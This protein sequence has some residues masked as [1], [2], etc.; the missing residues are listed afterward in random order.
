MKQTGSKQNAV[1]CWVREIKAVLCGEP[2]AK[3]M[4]LW[5]CSSVSCL[6]RPKG[7]TGGEG[8]EGSSLYFYAILSFFLFLTPP[9]SRSG[10]ETA[11]AFRIKPGGV[12]K[13]CLPCWKAPGVPHSSPSSAIPALS[14]LFG[15]LFS[16]HFCLLFCYLVSQGT[17]VLGNSILY[18][19]ADTPTAAHTHFQAHRGTKREPARESF[20]QLFASNVHQLCVHRAL[21]IKCCFN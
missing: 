17:A 3:H 18:L 13:S 19:T 9:P 20:N 15:E 10:R 11:L 16:R 1:N 21:M 5:P 4:S 8:L 7:S 6:P 12:Q 2:N 14:L